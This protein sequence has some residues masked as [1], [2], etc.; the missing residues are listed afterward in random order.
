MSDPAKTESLLLAVLFKLLSKN[1][2]IES[3]TALSWDEFLLLIS[4]HYRNQGYIVE[5]VGGPDDQGR[6]KP[7]G[8]IGSIS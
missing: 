6:P 3:I 8:G 7:D 1:P 2:T 4:A 5:V